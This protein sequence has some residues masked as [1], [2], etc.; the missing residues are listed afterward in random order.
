MPLRSDS[1]AVIQNELNQFICPK[2][3]KKPL[4]KDFRG[5]VVNKF[6]RLIKCIQ[7]NLSP[8]IGLG[9][10]CYQNDPNFKIFQEFINEEA[11]NKVQVTISTPIKKSNSNKTL[12]SEGPFKSMSNYFFKDLYD[13]K[14]STSKALDLFFEFAFGIENSEVLCKEFRFRCCQSETHDNSCKQKWTDLRDHLLE[15]GL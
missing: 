1:S 13:N 10:S 2:S 5:R 12:A 14:E 11:I 4:F 7:N 8:K 6:N 15:Q 9:S 3:L